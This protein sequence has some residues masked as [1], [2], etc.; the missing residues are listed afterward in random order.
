MRMLVCVRQVYDPST[1]RISRRREELDLREAIKIINPFDRHALETALQLRS[2][3]SGEVISVTVGDAAAEDVAHEA[4]AIGAD[5]ALLIIGVGGTEGGAALAETLAQP[6]WMRS[7]GG[8]AVARAVVAAVQ[9]L[10][11]IDL[12]LTGQVGWL[13]GT[14]S[15]A[16]RLA[17]ALGWPVAL[18]V[19][20]LAPGNGGLKAAV[21]F[22]D[23]AKEVPLPMPAVAA[24][25]PGPERPR[26]PHAARIAVAWQPGLVDVYSAAELGLESETLVAETEAGALILSPERSRGQMLSG[27]VEQAAAAL[28]DIL[29]ARRLV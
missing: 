10:G 16:S 4:V 7:P 25:L 3:L 27:G 24:I 6:G 9:K 5:R 19:A 2:A 29:R 12:V 20:R 15:L 17:A 18:D 23:G 26:Y 1:V 22:T 8:A 11:S 28:M 21:A 13:D 14:G